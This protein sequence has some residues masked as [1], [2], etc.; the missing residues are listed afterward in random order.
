MKFKLNKE[1]VAIHAHTCA[2]GNIYLKKENRSPSSIRT[3]RTTKPFYR[4]IIEYTNTCPLLLDKMTSYIKNNYPSTY[5]Y[6]GDK[7]FRIQ[8][9]NMVLYKMM[10][11][12]GCGKSLDWRIPKEILNNNTF[13]RIWLAAFFDDE[14]SITKSGIYLYSS[15][16]RG[17]LQVKKLLESEKIKLSLSKRF[18]ANSPNPGYTI[19]IKSSSHKLFLKFVKFSHPNKIAAYKKYFNK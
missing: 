18:F 5:V 11:D 19:R 9:R 17:I 6:R 4:G 13:I 3:G 15:N 16:L 10:K 7:K 8:V 1:L 14:G 12:L 2:D